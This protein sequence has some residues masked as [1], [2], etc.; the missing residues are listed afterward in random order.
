MNFNTHIFSIKIDRETA[1]DTIGFI[2][3][4][5]TPILVNML[6]DRE[7]IGMDNDLEISDKEI[8]IKKIITQLLKILF[9]EIQYTVSM[10]YKRKVH[11]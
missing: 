4:F 1:T 5:K 8:L 3:R 6:L 2:P 10:R 9:A 11:M 7:Y